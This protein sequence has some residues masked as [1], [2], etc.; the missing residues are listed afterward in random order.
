MKHR[1]RIL[2][3]LLLTVAAAAVAYVSLRRDRDSGERG[4]S[5]SGNIELTE[6]RIAFK[7][8]GRLA[9]LNVREGDA[10]R[11]DS[12]IARLDQEQLLRQ[13]DRARAAVAQV[14]SQL[15]QTRTA[16]D[17]QRESYRG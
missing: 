5:F 2:V 13:V 3:V 9:E 7:V 6:V 1:R 4:I 15:Q 16:L 10:V 11:K 12:V 17:F 14:E 8:A